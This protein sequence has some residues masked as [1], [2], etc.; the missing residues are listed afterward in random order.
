MHNIMYFENYG[1]PG[2]PN[3]EKREW[4]TDKYDWD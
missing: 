3:G 1:L 4:E 2:H